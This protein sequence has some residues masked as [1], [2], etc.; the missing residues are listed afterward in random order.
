MQKVDQ[1]EEHRWLQ[2]LIGKWT[3]ESEAIMGPDAPPVKSTGTET[4]RGMG[5]FWFVGE[6]DITMPDGNSFQTMLTVGY[7]TEAKRYT[8]S[9][10]GSM[11]TKLWVYDGFREGNSLHLESKGPSMTGDGTT[12]TYRDSI[13]IVDDDHRIFTS[14]VQGADGTWTRFMTAHYRRVS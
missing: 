5:E 10:I 1:Q 11:M 3:Y 7:D 14:Q 4:F 2:K 8:G 13:E 6:G 9:W 12:V